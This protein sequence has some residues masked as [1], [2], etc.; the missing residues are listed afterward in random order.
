MKK[1]TAFLVS[2]LLLVGTAA[3]DNAAK[4]SGNAPNNPTENP[5]APDAKTVQNDKADAQGDVRRAQLNS[6]IRAREQRNNVTGGD[7]KR[8]DGDL[9]SEVRSKLEANIPAGQLTIAAKDGAVT[10]GGTVQN[11]QQLQKIEPLAKQIKGV[12]TV[13]VK[14]VVAPATNTTTK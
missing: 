7:T 14:A 10:V 11:D 4:T 2:G 1:L 13:S 8:A 3:C 5:K 12:K 9:E 6:D